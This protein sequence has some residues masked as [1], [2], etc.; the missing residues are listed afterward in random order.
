MAKLSSLVR[1]N[2]KKVIETSLEKYKSY[3]FRGR[4][5]TIGD[6]IAEV[7][8]LYKVQ[9]GEM[10]EFS[11]SQITGLALNLDKEKVGIVLFGSDREIK[12]N[13]VVKCVGKLLS[14]PV[15]YGFLSRTVD[16]L[17][18]PLDGLGSIDSQEIKHMDIKA[19][20]I[21]ARQSVY[22]PVTTGLK[23]VDSLVP[24]GRGQRE[25]II[26]DRQTG[27]TAIAIDAMINQSVIKS[28]FQT[29][30]RKSSEKL[31]CIYV[32][33]GQKRSTVA[34]L[35]KTLKKYYSLGHSIVVAATASD[36]AP[37][38]YIAPFAGCTLAEYFMHRNDHSLIVYDDLSKQAVAYRQLSLLLRRPPGREAYPGDVF[39]LH[40]RLLERAAKLKNLDHISGGTITALPVVET[41]EGDV[42]SY[43]PTNVISITDGQIFLETTLFYQGVR[44]AINVG[45]SVSRVGS[46]AQ[47]AAIKK[48]SGT[49]KLDLAL[50][51]EMA[52]FSSF[53]FDESTQELLRK[54]AELTE[55]LKQQQY[56]PLPAEVQVFVLFNGLRERISSKQMRFYETQVAPNLLFGLKDKNLLN[57]YQN[58]PI[59]IT[60]QSL[61]L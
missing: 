52:A 8:G 41:M 36:S 24:I 13:D 17:G 11:P 33:I 47:L 39:Y 19:P 29:D 37:L 42:S 10:V 5:I 26:G 31:Y 2:F 43:I 15:G 7:A 14:T 54:G 53:G 61:V 20:G 60:T 48:M 6:G 58:V 28:P 32:C 27:K 44:P 34:Q 30:K 55:M 49:L 46:S 45:L 18:N 22:E 38:Q 59:N 57:S 1:A 16:P 50:Y 25:L 21:P 40:S 12:E 56:K 9:S 51:R 4:V 35:V 23:A 3:N